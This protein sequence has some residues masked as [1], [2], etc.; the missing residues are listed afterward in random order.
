MKM[1]WNEMN[2]ICAAVFRCI[3]ISWTPLAAS[4]S[5]SKLICGHFEVVFGNEEDKK[6]N[7][8]ENEELEKELKKETQSCLLVR[9]RGL[10]AAETRQS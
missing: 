6:E 8:R 7:K 2:S 10:N 9:A 5:P 4:L 1:K 3:D